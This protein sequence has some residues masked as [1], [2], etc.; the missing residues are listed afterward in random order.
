[1][2]AKQYSFLKPI[3]PAFGGDLQNGKRKGLRPIDPKATIHLVL[4]SSRAKGAWS[5]LHR[6]NKMRIHDLLL[7]LA[8]ENGIKIYRYTN[9]GNHLHLLIKIR[10]RSAFQKFLR[11]F[12]GRVVMFITDA[13]KG[14]PQGKFW[15]SLAFTRI[16][17]WGK[18]FTRVTRYFLKNE[19][20]GLGL[21]TDFVKTL[22]QRGLIIFE[23]G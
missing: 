19:L 6:R 7:K 3:S 10:N 1:M 14:N 23:S 15:D 12:S 22:V 2:K 4:K 5:L 8:R 20:E 9:V 18:D 13:R 16:V 11:V 17:Q 21:A